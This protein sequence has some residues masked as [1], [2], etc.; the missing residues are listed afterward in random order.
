MT[1]RPVRIV[2]WP[3]DGKPEQTMIDTL[4]AEPQVRVATVASVD[5]LAAALPGADALVTVD[6]ALD[7]APRVGELLR[8]PTTTLRWMHVW[9]V[10]REGIALANLPATITITGPA[11]EPSPAVAQ[12]TFAHMM[13]FTRRL[14]ECER[15]TRAHTWS[16][17]VRETMGPLEGRTLLLVGFGYSGKYIARV[18]RAFEMPVIALTR[19]P[20]PDPLADEVRPLSDLHAV[21]PRADFIVLILPLVP[22]TRNL[23]GAAELALCKPTAVLVNM[24]RG[25]IVDQP[26][27][28][29][30]LHAGTIAGAALDV[31]TPEPLPPDDPLW[32]APNLIVSPHIGGT[33][34][35]R[36]RVTERLAANLRAFLNG[37]LVAN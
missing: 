34:T 9:T 31:T 1:D 15:L 19:T 33:G 14:P 21:L 35:P 26:A 3:R 24:A 17:T 29:A 12:Q 11:G 36:S 32:S 20:R 37:T 18:A 28:A 10:G 4:E 22:A 2:Y 7:V 27:L 25:E 16:T 5:E 23:I 13:V 30:A 6:F 8:A